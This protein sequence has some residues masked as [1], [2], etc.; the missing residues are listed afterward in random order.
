MIYS[1]RICDESRRSFA[2]DRRRS[3]CR[4]YHVVEMSVEMSVE[5]PAMKDRDDMVTTTKPLHADRFSLTPIATA[6]GLPPRLSTVAPMRWAGVVGIMVFVLVSLGAVGHSQDG[7]SAGDNAAAQPLT[8]MVDD[9]ITRNHYLQGLRALD[10]AFDAHKRKLPEAEQVALGRAVRALQRIIGESEYRDGLIYHPEL[11][12]YIGARQSAREALMTGGQRA[13]ELERDASFR[14][15]VLTAYRNEYNTSAQMAVEQARLN[16]NAEALETVLLRYPFTTAAVQAGIQ[17]AR[18]AWEQGHVVHA[19]ALCRRLLER[20]DLEESDAAMLAAIAVAAYAQAAHIYEAREMVALIAERFD[21]A[22]VQIGNRR[23]DIVGF[24][25]EQATLAVDRA[26]LPEF[27]SPWATFAGNWMR[28]KMVDVEIDVTAEKWTETLPS[29]TAGQMTKGFRVNYPNFSQPRHFPVVM[30]GVCYV[31]NRTGIRAYNLFTKQL[32]WDFSMPINSRV[33]YWMN[34]LDPSVIFTAT[35]DGDEVFVPLETPMI[36][37]IHDPMRAGGHNNT[38][39]GM[40]FHVVIH[41]PRRQLVCLDRRTGQVKWQIGADWNDREAPL[42]HTLSYGTAP[43]VVGDALFVAGSKVANENAHVY[44]TSFTRDAADTRADKPAP[45]LRWMTKLIS[46]LQET[47]LFGRPTREPFPS[48]VAYQS[49]R[50][51]VNSN[52][53]LVACLDAYTGEQVWAAP[54]ERIEYSTPVTL[55][56]VFRPLSWMNNPPI[57]VDGKLIVAPMDADRLFC[58]DATTGTRLWSV[59]YRRGR[60]ECRIVAGVRNDRIILL[61]DTQIH[62]LDLRDGQPVGS[63]LPMASGFVY[64]SQFAGRPV[65]SN[66][67]MYVPTQNGIAVVDLDRFRIVQTLATGLGASAG[68]LA[69]GDGTL[70]SIADTRRGIIGGTSILKVAYDWTRMIAD[71][72]RQEQLEPSNIAIKLRIAN[73]SRQR[74]PSTYADAL[75]YFDKVVQLTA[76]VQTLEAELANR[77]AHRGLFGLWMDEVE[78]AKQVRDS[79][80]M[81]RALVQAKTHAKEPRDAVQVLLVELDFARENEPAKQIAVL[82]EMIERYPQVVYEFAPDRIMPVALFAH[83]QIAD[84]AERERRHPLA[85]AHWQTLLERF[86]DTVYQARSIREQAIAAIKRLIDTH[87]RPVYADIERRAV[88]QVQAAVTRRDEPALLGVAFRYPNSIAA[89]TAL[90]TVARWNL[91]GR[92]GRAATEAEIETATDVLRRLLRE[93]PTTQWRAEVYVLLAESYEMRK[94]WH[95]ARGVFQQLAREFAGQRILVRGREMLV[96]AFVAE[97]LRKPEYEGIVEVPSAPEL[98]DVPL[99]LLDETSLGEQANAR[100]FD[101][102]GVAP[103]GLD[104]HY[105]VWNVRQLECRDSANGQQIWFNADVMMVYDL[106]YVS[107]RLVVVGTSAVF[108]LDPASGRTVWRCDLGR[109]VQAATI[110]NGVA[111]VLLRDRRPADARYEFWLAVINAEDGSM[112]GESTQKYESFILSNPLVHHGMALIHSITPGQVMGYRIDDP[113]LPAFEL[114]F[115]QR[116]ITA[117][118]IVDD[119][120]FAIA[121]QTAIFVYRLSD[122]ALLQQI[123]TTST[124]RPD[125]LFATA[126]GKSLTYY[127]HASNVV[128]LDPGTGATRWTRAFQASGGPMHRTTLLDDTMLVLIRTSTEVRAIAVDADNGRVRWETSLLDDARFDCQTVMHTTKY[129]VVVLRR[130]YREP[131]ADGNSRVRTDMQAIIV[132]RATGRA[133]QRINPTMGDTLIPHLLIKGGALYVVANNRVQKYGR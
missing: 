21:T 48:A 125:G 73:L 53:G 13:N 55:N 87:G 1:G 11:G 31:P 85:V 77:D 36:D 122:G 45:R 27:A 105:Y 111:V 92:D 120:R 28:N 66:H 96:D 82:G 72:K 71:L 89:Q 115:D 67:L 109:Q 110:A 32:M 15:A 29:P 90:L 97:A 62:L 42:H 130:I 107:S 8:G 3:A 25:R 58:F 5:M 60:D 70:V 116:L 17:A 114:N 91:A 68:N 123:R 133:L 84:L 103:P 74:G 46:G 63:P 23:R 22:T 117:P 101:P 34:E 10:D 65:I 33:E 59:P 54:Y 78:R 26:K 41:T 99:R 35:A 93:H 47:N 4:N 131:D 40:M 128:S 7:P 30:D 88:E 12:R 95:A 18:I 126:G 37:Q 127:D 69:V 94:M 129:F 61:G 113:R 132:D 14:K 121:T 119:E 108:G 102:A 39:L 76:N 57:V 104:D 79:R 20:T 112:I 75:A 9:P 64:G 49:H 100:L 6:P 98:A 24:A 124:V 16:R 86:G 51:F 44:V 106:A 38:P 43:V 19:A 50:V 56:P 118:I 81:Q 80:R 52:L 83:L 2:D